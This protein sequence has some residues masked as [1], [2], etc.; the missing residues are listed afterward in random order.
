MA[1]HVS[2]FTAPIKFALSYKVPLILYG[3]NPQIEY[4]G[5][6]KSLSNYN[7]DRK[8]MEEFGGLIGLRVSDL[9]EIHNFSKKELSIYEYPSQ[10]DLNKF[11]IKSIFLGYFEHGI[12]SGILKFLKKMVFYHMI[13]V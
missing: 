11:P 6:E 5:P 10:E 2:I 13:K 3:E 9:I 1:E 12:V 4:G 8:W 7:L